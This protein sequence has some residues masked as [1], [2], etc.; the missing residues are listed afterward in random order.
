MMP[1]QQL[2]TKTFHEVVPEGQSSFT[3]ELPRWFLSAS[4]PDSEMRR[5]QFYFSELYLI[6]GFYKQRAAQL[7]LDQEEEA[8][9]T[10]DLEFRFSCDVSPD[11]FKDATSNEEI[12]YEQGMR[13][14]RID[15]LTKNINAHFEVKKPEGI[16]HAVFFL[17]WIDTEWNNL[18]L[19]KDPN[20][21]T[22]EDESNLQPKDIVLQ[23]LMEYYGTADYSEALHFNCLELSTRQ[24]P[25]VNNFKFPPTAFTSAD[26]LNKIRMR[27][28]IGPNTKVLF[29]TNTLLEQLGFSVEQIGTATD[30]KRYPFENN[31]SDRYVTIVA[32]NPVKPTGV[33]AGSPTSILPVVVNK[34]LHSNWKT[35]QMK[36]SDFDNNQQ[37]LVIVKEAFAKVSSQTNIAVDLDYNERTKTFK[38]L[39]PQNDRLSVV[40][41][42]ERD[43]S[44]RL[45]YENR[46][47]ITSSVTSVPVDIGSTKVD[48]EEQSRALSYDTVMALV[49]MEQSSSA[50]TD[51]LDET[52][53]ACLF[54]TS[55]G[56]MGM[57]SRT[58]CC[59]PPKRKK[60]K[61]DDGFTPK[62]IHRAA[63][64]PAFNSGNHT[65]FVKFNIWTTAKNSKMEPLNWK[66][67]FAIGGVLEGK[68]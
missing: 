8:N 28:H 57:T 23:M 19:E 27:M 63:F 62:L 68:V 3:I 6:P 13:A 37:M 64:L 15:Q 47:N 33:I 16:N 53:M 41:H 44:K 5:R 1:G 38:I 22:E 58:C 32:K 31:N 65:T 21:S 9:T 56:T 30:K 14:N 11:L 54:P 35:I 39:F 34:A 20:L 4:L 46:T 12:K 51:S 25:G 42:C 18:L 24:L 52:L 60:K 61:K 29:S 7:G 43:F 2:V 10:I 45:G 49:T 40:V 17:D 36:M 59:S 26:R 66:I 67:P 55:S 50:T 48:A